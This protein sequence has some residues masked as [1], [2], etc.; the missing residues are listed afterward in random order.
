MSGFLTEVQIILH[1]MWMRRWIALGVAWGVA[2]LGWAVVA[3]L[4]NS[5]ESRAR[6]FVQLNT[7]LP[8]AVGITAAD[9]QKDVDTIRQTLTSAVNLEKV[10]RGT[11][12]ANT[13]KTDRD[14]ADRVNTLSKAIKITAQQDNLFEI[15]A[16][17]SSPKV[18]AQIVQKLIDLFVEQNL[19]GD[20]DETN[21]SLKF[22]D[23]QLEQRQKQL[24]DADAK[25]ADFQNRYLGS[26]PGSGSLTDRMG[27]ARSAMA[28]VD[29]DL[30]AAQSALS[31]VN[32]QM[33]GTPANIPGAAGVA[34]S[35][36]PARA[37]LNAIQGQLADARARGYTENH[38]DVVA[39]R[40]QLA[41]AQAAARSEP[42][43]GGGGAASASNP[44]YLGLRSIQADKQAQVAALSARKGQLQHDLDAINGKLAGD[45]AVAAQQSQIDNDYQVMKDSYAKLLADREAIKLRGQAQSQTD[46]I[47]FS[48]IDPPTAPRVPASPN[49]PLL[50]TGVLIAALGAGVAV[51]FGLTQFKTT[52]ATAG[53]LEKAAG[54]PVIG[55]I[56]A[57][58][59]KAQL[60][61]RRRMLAYFAGGVGALGA[62]YIG[63]LGVEM[64]QRGLA[65]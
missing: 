19:S 24:A 56:G 31:V 12:L 61:H 6:V 60:A 59:T 30:A 34:A 17:G 57:I 63:L 20:R 27:A 35:A 36:G 4:H 15:V 8:S 13:V 3:Q 58:V 42:M 26:L 49:R 39:L 1:T 48:V 21:S 16:S 11:D 28:Q 23:A 32:G 43:V 10:V 55:S 51:A 22:L 47:K 5:Y 65:A 40:S 33:A 45:P 14:V 2:V 38:P 50:L 54:L 62:A 7:I 53:R 44:A 41:S 37:R 9:Q 29:S 18:T 25:R 64:L 52:F 46:S